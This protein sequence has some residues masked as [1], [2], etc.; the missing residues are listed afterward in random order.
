MEVKSLRQGMKPNNENHHALNMHYYVRYSLF[1]L[2]EPL[3]LN[4][5][6]M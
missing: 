6:N 4:E 5:Q 3:H 1:L 2:I